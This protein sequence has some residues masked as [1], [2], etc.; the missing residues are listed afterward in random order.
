MVG[1]LQARG[2]GIGRTKISAARRF[3]QKI[4]TLMS[5]LGK[6]VDV[7]KRR[8]IFRHLVPYFGKTLP[9]KFYRET[10]SFIAGLE[11]VHP[12]IEGIYKPAWSSYALS[13]A[14]MLKSP[15]SDKISFNV[16]RSWSILYSP[17][18]GGLDL[19]QNAALVRCMTDQE[20]VLVMQQISDKQHRTGAH[21]R[22]LGLG[23]ILNFDPSRQLF[24]IRGLHWEEISRYVDEPLTDEL[25]PTALRLE[26]LEDWAPFLK[27]DRAIYRASRIRRDR[28][29]R[30]VVLENYDSTCAVTG[31][32]FVYE[33]H[34]EA[35]AA[36]IIAKDVDGTDDPRN[37]LALS[38]TAHWAFDLGVFTISDQYEIIV[39]PNANRAAATR[40]PILEMDRRKVFLSALS[41]W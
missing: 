17:K 27:E 38:K 39:H 12:L 20:P 30:E 36:H 8:G 29:F 2:K 33:N 21:H 9:A 7:E 10:S 32:K 23:L 26:A 11:R 35:D 5:S 40:F 24:Q 4:I 31:Q 3:G 19:A 28:A 14:S 22:L 34:T 16:D 6:T 37:G 41:E 18:V 13:V 15:Y 1:G 25:L